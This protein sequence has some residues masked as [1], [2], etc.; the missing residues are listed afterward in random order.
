[1]TR[2][3]VTNGPRGWRVHIEEGGCGPERVTRATVLNVAEFRKVCSE[4]AAAAQMFDD[5]IHGE[6]A[7]HPDVQSGTAASTLWADA[8][9]ETGDIERELALDEQGP[10]LTAAEFTDDAFRVADHTDRVLSLLYEFSRNPL[11]GGSLVFSLASICGATRLDTEQAMEVAQ[12]LVRQGMAEEP[13]PGKFRITRR[14]LTALTPFPPADVTGEQ[15]RYVVLVAKLL[16][17]RARCEL[18]DDDEE[19]RYVDELDRCWWAMSRSEQDEVECVIPKA[20]LA[21]K[22][23]QAPFSPADVIREAS[24]HLWRKEPPTAD[25]V[26]NYPWWWNRMPDGT[27]HVIH[28]DVRI[29]SDIVIDVAEAAAHDCGGRFDHEE[30]PGEWAACVPPGGKP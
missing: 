20:L 23:R 7:N 4:Y 16:L 14:G 6:A 5:A 3:E 25:E 2:F 8:Y 1:M 15:E 29:G 28:L 30:W 9:D 22:M 26:R 21:M 27:C 19:A 13:A 18:P 12:A 24:E 17:Q 11:N 10:T